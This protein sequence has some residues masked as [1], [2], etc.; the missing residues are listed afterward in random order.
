MDSGNSYHFIGDEPMP[1]TTY[2]PL[3]QKMKQYAVIGE[4]WPEHQLTYKFAVLRVLACPDAGKDFEPE[5]V[6][7]FENNQMMLP[8][9]IR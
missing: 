9:Q 2:K 4:R 8:F 1:W 6:E 5:L 3:L 7:R